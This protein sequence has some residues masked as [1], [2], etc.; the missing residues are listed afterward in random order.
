MASPALRPF[1]ET[2]IR[3]DTRYDTNGD[4]RNG[5]VQTQR[6]SAILLLSGTLFLRVTLTYRRIV[7]D[8]TNG[9]ECKIYRCII[10]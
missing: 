4:C 2:D 1:S 7:D 9:N 10:N 3:R 6:H 8:A 5:S